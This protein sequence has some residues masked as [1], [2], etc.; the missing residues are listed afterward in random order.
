MY[1]GDKK[2]VAAFV[3]PITSTLH[4]TASGTL[5]KPEGSGTSLFTMLAGHIFVDTQAN[6]MYKKFINANNNI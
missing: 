5:S 4:L 1:L 3:A 2:D 6:G